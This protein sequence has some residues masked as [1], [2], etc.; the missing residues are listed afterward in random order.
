VQVWRPFIAASTSGFAA[1]VPA[2]CIDHQRG[3]EKEVNYPLNDHHPNDPT[4]VIMKRGKTSPQTD[5][6]PKVAADRHYS[7]DKWYLAKYCE[8]GCV[9]SRL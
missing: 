9:V 4:H 7:V 2:P 8:V 6:F 5:L 1:D 3:S